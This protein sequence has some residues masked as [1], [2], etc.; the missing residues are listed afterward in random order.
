MQ[1]G[2]P[3]PGQVPERGVVEAK[4]IDYEIA[5]FQ[6]SE[7]VLKYLKKYNVVL[8]TNLREFQ[9]VGLDDAGHQIICESFTLAPTEDEFLDLLDKP[10][11]SAS[12]IGSSLGEFLVRVLSHRTTITEPKDV[13]WL[14]ASYARDGL[15][16]IN[17]AGDDASL[18]ALRKALEEALGIQ[19]TGSQGAR[20]FRSTLIQTLFYGVFS[21]WVLWSRTLPP[22]DKSVSFNWKLASDYLQI[23]II[24]TLFHQLSQPSRLKPL[25]LDLVLGWT[26]IALNRVNRKAFFDR[27]NE[28]EEVQYF[29]EPFLEAFDPFLRKQLGVWYTP[30]DVV[31]YMVARVDLALK[32]DLNIP[33]GLAAKNVFVL[34]P[35]CG[36]GA[37]LS[38]V[39]QRIAC[40]LEALGQGAL[41]GEMVKQAVTERVFGFEIMP[42]PY[43]VAHLQVGL[44]MQ[45][46]NAPLAENGT[47]RAGVYLTNALIGW[48]PRVNKP[49]SLFPELEEERKRAD[50][51]KQDEPILVILGNP[52]YDGFAGVAV[53]EERALSDAYRNPKKVRRPEG[54]GLNDPFVRFFRMAEHRIAEKTNKG[55]VC[56]ISN[57]NWLNGMSYTAMRERYLDVFDVVRIDCL[58]GGT[59]E[60]G[61]TPEG[62]PD[63][64]VFTVLGNSVGIMVGTAIATL[65]RK[66]DHKPIKRIEFRHLWGQNK[67]EKLLDTAEDK[68]GKLYEKLKPVLPLGLPFLPVKVSEDWF[69]WPALPELFRTSFP[70]VTTSRDGFLVDVDLDRLKERVAEYFDTALSHEEFKSRYPTVMENKARYNAQTVRDSLQAIGGPD[71]SDFIRLSYRPFDTRWLYWNKSGPLLDRPRAEY[72]PHVF[73]GNVWLSA[74]QHLRKGEDEPQAC[75]TEHMG[76]YHLIERGSSMFP[77]WLRDVNHEIGEEGSIFDNLTGQAKKYIDHL[78]ASIDDLF[79]YILS[80]LHDPAYLTANAGPLS[81]DWPRIP[82][83]GWPKG[84]TN[85]AAETFLASAAKGRRIAALLD[86]DVSIHSVTK[87]PLRQDL[88]KIAVPTTSD[89]SNMTGDDFALTAGWGHFGKG[90]AVIPGKGKTDERDYYENE[91]GAMGNR[92]PIYGDTTF[93]VHLNKCAFWSN[94]PLAV[95]NY[96]LGG[97]QVLKKWLSYREQTILGRPLIADEVACFRDIARRIAAILTLDVLE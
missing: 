37:F 7:Q 31:R 17:A 70:G 67:H 89:G 85:G 24:A 13:A 5:E 84:D 47:E 55:V 35:C 75:F 22:D 36:T 71:E 23:P 57:Y 59:R 96:N 46:L 45:N 38:A 56:F 88:A 41:T 63:A 61:E 30:A 68:P 50:Q 21:A 44:T 60:G 65:V 8:L 72:R 15:A 28:G 26:S 29:Y 25:G 78:D 19:F 18:V 42:A 34:D 77:A 52:P 6:S 43:V 76:C 51:V 92:L 4:S 33:E 90:E 82:L 73:E 93:D 69:R 11:A 74:A 40:N 66:P 53:N 81:M 49:I 27:F 20:F 39:L 58:N 16:R 54:S 79:Y 94:I 3:R 91:Q 83:P 95:W 32:N 64:S 87:V 12:E 1:Q 2:L 80:V 97:Y 10:H 48:E 86:T 14:L 9:L 62:K